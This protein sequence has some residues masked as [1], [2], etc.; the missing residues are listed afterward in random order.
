MSFRLP[1][2]R[3]SEGV[4]CREHCPTESCSKASAE[5]M[6]K[7]LTKPKSTDFLFHWGMFWE[8]ALTLDLAR[9]IFKKSWLVRYG[10]IS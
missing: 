5:P 8:V 9:Q 2:F 1:P 6:F 7:M 3:R 10:L 4:F